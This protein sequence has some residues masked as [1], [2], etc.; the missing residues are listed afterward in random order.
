[1]PYGYL[2]QNQPNQTVSNSGVFSITDVAELQSQ[3]K[4]GGS[5]ELIATETYSSDVSYIDF[6]SI[7]ENKF[8]VHFMSILKLTSGASSHQHR[9]QFY[10]SDILETANVY[11]YAFQYG[12]VTGSFGDANRGTNT[13][14]AI[15]NTGSEGIS[16]NG[17]LYFYNLGD[18]S[19]YSFL[20]HHNFSDRTGAD[21]FTFGSGVMKQSSTVDGIRLLTTSGNFTD[22]DISLYGIAES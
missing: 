10:E 7:Q 19:K 15:E 4:L 9:I 13:Q 12:S 21:I 5:L 2:G 3:G 14:L 22:F 17:Y 20:T 11:D 6:L 16:Q 8:D 18:S 1:M